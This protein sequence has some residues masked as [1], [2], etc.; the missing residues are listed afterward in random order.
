MLCRRDELGVERIFSLLQPA[1]VLID[2][3]GEVE[4]VLGRDLLPATPARVTERLCGREGGVSGADE[5]QAARRGLK[6]GWNGEI[7]S[8]KA[9]A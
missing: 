2:K 3:L 9:N 5:R 8:A 7:V 6:Q 1:R 4:G